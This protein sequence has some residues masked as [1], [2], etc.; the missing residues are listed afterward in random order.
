MIYKAWYRLRR[1][2]RGRQA[3][4]IQ[5]KR[6]CQIGAQGAGHRA[7]LLFTPKRQPNFSRS[8]FQMWIE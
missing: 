1:S 6:F 5:G 8:R 2:L 3:D 7:E 4:F